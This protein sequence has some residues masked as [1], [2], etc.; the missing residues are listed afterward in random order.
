[1]LQLIYW[2][3]K[4]FYVEQRFITP[5]DGF[6]RAIVLSKQTIL[7]ATADEMMEKLMEGEKITRPAKPAD[8]DLWMRSMD[9]SSEKLRPHKDWTVTRKTDQIT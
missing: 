6:V 5:H 4:S 7:K 3:D 1:M 2:E 8:L 9:A